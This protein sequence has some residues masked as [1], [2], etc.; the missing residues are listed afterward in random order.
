MIAASLSIFFPFAKMPLRPSPKCFA[1]FTA[2]SL[3]EVF[4]LHWQGKVPLTFPQAPRS[5]VILLLRCSQ[6]LPYPG[7]RPNVWPWGAWRQSLSCR[8]SHRQPQESL[9]RFLLPRCFCD[10]HTD[11]FPD[12]LHHWIPKCFGQCF[13]RLI[14]RE[15]RKVSF[16][17]CLAGFT[18]SLYNNTTEGERGG[19][20][21]ASPVT[22]PFPADQP[23]NHS[24]L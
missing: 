1:P 7:R 11:Q 22:T 12:L 23:R 13:L 19:A 18:G 9:W 10:L 8:K 3:T 2:R 5:P 16:L 21:K 24:F 6:S 4:F 17:S 14:Y 15:N 20:A